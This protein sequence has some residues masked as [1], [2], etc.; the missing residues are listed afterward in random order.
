VQVEQV[1]L[2]RLVA[3][4]DLTRYSAQLLPQVEVQEFLAYQMPEVLV[5][6]VVRA[7]AV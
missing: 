2:L 3:Q 7:V 6:V 5:L 4:T 1:E